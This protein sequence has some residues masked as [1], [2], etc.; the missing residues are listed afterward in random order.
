MGA[1]GNNYGLLTGDGTIAGNIINQSGGEV[2]AESGKTLYFTHPSTGIPNAGRLNLLGGTLNYGHRLNNNSNGQING[3]GVLYFPTS[4]VP[5]SASPTAGLM[6]AGQ[7]NLSG[8]DSQ[9]YGTVQMEAGSRLIVS[10]GA[11]ATFY[12]VFRHNGAEVKASAGSSLVFFGEVRGAG[13]FTGSGTIYME[14]GYS[15]GNSPAMVTLDAPIVLGDANVLTLELGG[16][17]A[18]LG[19]GVNP[20]DGYDQLTLGTGGALTLDGTLIIDLINDFIPLVGQTFQVFDFQPGQISGSF[21]EI[22]F[23]D[24]L[25]SGTSFDTSSLLTNGKVAVVPEP[26]SA[27]LLL[28]GLALAARRRRK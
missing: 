27:L 11:T 20:L 5:S 13:S 22:V 6:N 7:M 21:D 10:G 19:L 25:P 8:G 28:G 18:G 14:G 9:I 12:D 15:P 17:T 3:H 24:A 1:V 4:P 16:L 26:S 23:A 2:R